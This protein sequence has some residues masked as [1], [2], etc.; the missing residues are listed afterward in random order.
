[1]GN[2][3]VGRCLTARIW[4]DTG[5]PPKGAEKVLT[6]RDDTRQRVFQKPGTPSSGSPRPIAEYIAS[7]CGRWLGVKVPTVHLCN[8][9]GPVSLSCSVEPCIPWAELKQK[10]HDHLFARAVERLAD[11]AGVVVLDLLVRLADEERCVNHS[12]HLYSTAEDAWYSIDYAPSLC[13][14]KYF[15]RI[16]YQDELIAAMRSNPQ[17]IAATL[18]RAQDIPVASFTLLLDSIPSSFPATTPTKYD[19]IEQ[20]R[21]QHAVLADVVSAWCRAKSILL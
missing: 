12:N 5:E 1:M 6:L 21:G 11:F 15:G 13:H 10:P 3:T 4:V 18:R 20:L 2:Y 14:S 16:T 8:S 17:T 9:P 7:V 19:L